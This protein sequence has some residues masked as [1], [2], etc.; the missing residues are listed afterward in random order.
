MTVYP[1]IALPPLLVGAVKLTVAW[2]LPAV[3]M[4]IIGALGIVAG[5]LTV[6]TVTENPLEGALMPMLLLAV[7]EH[8]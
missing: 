7:A 8:E 6:G 3:A 5:V 4:P 1:V 2:A